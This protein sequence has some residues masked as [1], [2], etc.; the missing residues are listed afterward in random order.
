[1]KKVNVGI[2]G[3]G[4]IGW[5]VYEAILKNASLIKKRTGISLSIKAVCDTD[6]KLL[7]AVDPK[8]V[9]LITE[10]YEELLNDKEVDIVVELVGGITIAKNIILMAII[11]SH[12]L[13]ICIKS[14]NSC[15]WG[16]VNRYRF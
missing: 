14:N 2:I 1:M 10:S 13:P 7:K 16:Y 9:S 4:T 15:L 8:K 5:G 6:T 3:L 11:M 12:S